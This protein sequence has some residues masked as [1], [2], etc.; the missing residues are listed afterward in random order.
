[1]IS[2]LLKIL[3]SFFD[4]TVLHVILQDNG[5]QEPLKVLSVEEST[6]EKELL[7]SKVGFTLEIDTHN[8]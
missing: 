4:F 5:E 3:Y 2:G 6:W 8:P 1:M 7:C